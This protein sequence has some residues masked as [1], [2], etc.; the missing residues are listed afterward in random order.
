MEDM[1]DGNKMG[2]VAAKTYRAM[3]SPKGKR[4]APGYEM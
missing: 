2:Y 1:V 3:G 4:K